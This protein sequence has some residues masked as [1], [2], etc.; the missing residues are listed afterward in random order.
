MATNTNLELL[1]VFNE[2]SSVILLSTG[3]KSYSKCSVKLSREV[4]SAKRKQLVVPTECR[5]KSEKLVVHSAST[6]NAASSQSLNNHSEL[7]AACTKYQHDD[8]I[9]S[10]IGYFL[11]RKFPSDDKDD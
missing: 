10:Q 1:F 3:L 6:K 11:R 7:P 4:L 9:R 5:W 8:H 2:V